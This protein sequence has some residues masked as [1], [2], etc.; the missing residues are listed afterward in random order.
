MK[1]IVYV[2]TRHRRS[3]KVFRNYEAAEAEVKNPEGMSI[4]TCEVE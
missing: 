1:Q 4:S 2:V 3:P